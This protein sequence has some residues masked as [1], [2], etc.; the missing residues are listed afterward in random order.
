MP[1]CSWRPTFTAYWWH[2]NAPLFLHCRKDDLIGV[3]LASLG[4]PPPIVDDGWGPSTIND[5]YWHY[6]RFPLEALPRDKVRI[7]PM[8]PPQE[9]I[10]PPP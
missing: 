10:W 3:D 5:C 9:E 7:Q 2:F 1:I 4:L 6:H 8:P